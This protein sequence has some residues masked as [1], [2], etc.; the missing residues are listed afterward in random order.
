MLRNILGNVGRSNGLGTIR[1]PAV[2]A[3]P[4][5]T[6]FRRTMQASG[7]FTSTGVTFR[8]ASYVNGDF[9]LAT[10]YTVQA[11]EEATFGW[12]DEGHPDNQGYIFVRYQT[13]APT[14]IDG[15]IRLQLEDAHGV[16]IA[17]G[18]VLEDDSTL[19]D[20]SS[21]DRRIM[22]PLPKWGLWATED[23]RLAIRI[24]PT[25]TAAATLADSTVQ[26]PFTARRVG[27]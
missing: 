7:T 22:R 1:L 16:P 4:A 27:R 13:T 5:T 25:A 2:G 18:L 26:V 10:Y 20:G 3:K 23:S 6:E 14:A 11:Q 15:P 9:N 19:L 17:G 21:T 8:A 24:D 12:G